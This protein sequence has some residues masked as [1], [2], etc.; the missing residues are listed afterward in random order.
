M[1]T[2]SNSGNWNRLR[3][4][5][6][7]IPEQHGWKTLL[8]GTTENSRIEHCTQNSERANV[9]VQNVLS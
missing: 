5:Q 1:N 8:Q 6:N 2:G 3:I 7:S 9:R 4:I